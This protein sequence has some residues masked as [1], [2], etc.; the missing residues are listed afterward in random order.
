[1]NCD[2]HMPIY[3]AIKMDEPA[4][5]KMFS[6]CL[7]LFLLCLFIYF[8]FYFIF[9]LLFK[10]SCLQ[11]LPTIHPHPSHPSSHPLHPNHPPSALSMGHSY[12]F[13]TTLPPFAPIIPS[14]IPSLYFMS[15]GHTYKLFDFYI[16]Y[17][18]LTLPLSIF[19]LPFMLLILC[20]FP[21]SPPLP[22]C[23]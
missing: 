20:T 17:T 18:I 8:I 19:Y 7:S 23:H 15:F 16:S 21:P 9:L 1:M 4:T 22:L 10:Y 12:I 2:K 6:V 5:I 14:H 11:F 13:L 3:L